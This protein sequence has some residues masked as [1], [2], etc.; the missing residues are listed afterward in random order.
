MYQFVSDLPN[1]LPSNDTRK[2]SLGGGFIMWYNKSH[3]TVF[4]IGKSEDSG[5]C[6]NMNN[7]TVLEKISAETMRFI[8]GKYV[9]DEAGD[10]KDE[11]K[12]R[13][14]R[15]TVLT[16]YI[17]NDRY[18]FLVIFGKAE[19]EKFEAR[20]SEFP[21]KIQDIYNNSK[22]YHDGKWMMIP[23]TDLETLET[24]KQMIIMKKN[25]NRK[26]FSK[27]QAIYSDCGHRC[28]LCV[29]YTGETISDELRKE[30]QERIKRVYEVPDAEF[31]PCD[32][33]CNGGIGGKHDCD[34][35]KCAKE[36]RFDKCIDCSKYPCDKATA[37]RPPRI[38]IK[39]NLADDVTWAILPYVDGQYGN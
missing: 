9:L 21:K 38:E 39:S 18:D 7:K 26:P 20:R 5:W 2:V 11:L 17:R 24:I 14:G 4:L 28:D 31:P 22:T 8:R 29:H 25:P 6:F 27:E 15:K 19:R 10:G 37:G 33:C 3:I 35:K 30:L 12:F 36:K 23:V 13:C 34:Q 16:I 32:G 1:K